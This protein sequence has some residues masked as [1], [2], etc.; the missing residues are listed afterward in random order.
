MLREYDLA[1][2]QFTQRLIVE[3][4]QDRDNFIKGQVNTVL[5][6]ISLDQTDC[7]IHYNSE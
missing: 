6:L 1:D 2:P 4:K 3:F 7:N 5:T